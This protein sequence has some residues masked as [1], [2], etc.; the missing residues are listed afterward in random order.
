MKKFFLYFAWLALVGFAIFLFRDQK[1]FFPKVDYQ[2]NSSSDKERWSNL[3]GVF[4]EVSSGLSEIGE[5]TQAFKLSKQINKDVN[6]QDKEEGFYYENEK[7]DFSF[8]FDKNY[9]DSKEK[10]GAFDLITDEK[11]VLAFE[12]KIIGADIRAII[13]E[14]K[15]DGS[16]CVAQILQSMD[17]KVLEEK[18]FFCMTSKK[19]DDIFFAMDCFL[20]QDNACYEINYEIVLNKDEKQNDEEMTKWSNMEELI[21]KNLVLKIK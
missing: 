10:I 8:V 18:E 2:K 6:L 1:T 21:L 13:N 15:K 17:K 7:T 4:G 3:Q 5:V 16:S 12:Y 9:F 19:Q 20:K 11:S 14:N